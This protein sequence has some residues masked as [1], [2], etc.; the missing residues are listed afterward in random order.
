MKAQRRQNLDRTMEAPDAVQ[1]HSD[2]KASNHRRPFIVT[3]D[4]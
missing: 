3:D 2:V 1:P 4:L